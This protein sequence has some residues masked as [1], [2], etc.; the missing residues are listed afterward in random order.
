[1]DVGPTLAA[2]ADYFPARLLVHDVAGFLYFQLINYV[3]R[4][5]IAMC[6]VCLESW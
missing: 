3:V 6:G 2:E 1:M 4:G 5:I